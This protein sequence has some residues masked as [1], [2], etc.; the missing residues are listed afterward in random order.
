MKPPI[1]LQ[2]LF[3]L[4]LTAA[5]PLTAGAQTT[6]FFSDDFTSG[7]ASTVNQPDA[8][9][10]THSTSYQ[11]YLNG[12]PSTNTVNP[13]SLTLAFP[14]STSIIGELAGRFTNSPVP[15][16]ADGDFLTL[17]VIF[18]NTANLLTNSSGNS[19]L[20]VGLYNS[21]GA[22]LNQGPTILNALTNIANT[23]GSQGWI[24]YVS[25]MFANGGNATCYTRNP[26]T[27]NGTSAQNQDLLF[28]NASSTAGYNLPT[29]TVLTGG[30]TVS[31]AAGVITS[32]PSSVYTLV[33][34]AAFDTPTGVLV[35]NTLYSGAGTGGTVVFTQTKT[36]TNT[37]FVT[38]GFDS[39]AIGWRNASSV[40]QVTTMDINS[41]TVVGHS[42][43]VTGPPH[44]DSQPV[45][46]NIPS[47]SAG[48]F[49]VSATGFG[50]GYQWHRNGTNLLN[51][52][53]IS[54]A[55][56]SI[57]VINPAGPADVAPSNNPNGYY[58]TV[59]GAGGYFTNS[60]TNAL[61][62]TTATNLI[63]SGNLTTWDL[64]NTADWLDPLSNLVPFNFGDPVTFDDTGAGGNVNLAG[65]FLSAASVTV[66][67][68]FNYNFASTSS[69]SFAGPGS[70][71][72]SGPGQLTIGNVNTYTGGTSITNS[73]TKILLQNLSG[74]GSGPINLA[75]PAAQI[76]IT[77]A[78]ATGVGIASDVN[79]ADN[80]AITF[81]AVGT[82]S[83][84]FNGDWSGTVGKTLTLNPSPT[85]TVLNQRVRLLG[86]NTVY[87]GNLVLNASCVTVANY[88][89]SGNHIF[90]G[91]VSG[92]GQMMQRGNGLTIF[93]GAN[94]Y[95]GG[96][97]PTT[98]AIGFGI[99]SVGAVTT[100]PIGTGPLILAPEIP[101]LTG[102][103]AVLAYG[104][105]RT[106]A[107]PIQYP[108]ATNNLTLIT[109]GT[110]NLTFSGPYTL[111]GLDGLGT[112]NI[113]TFQ[114]DNAGLTTISGVISDGGLAYGLTK[115]GTNTLALSNTETYTGPTTVSA[116]IL[117]VNGALNAASTV[118][119]TTNATLAGTGTINGA[120]TITNGTLAPGAASI[121][122][123]NLANNLTFTGTGGMK[124]RVNRS[125]SQADK[126]I[127]G[128]TLSN[129]GTGIVT[130]TN[131]G[132]TL[133]VGDTF[134]LFSTSVA[135][136]GALTVTGGGVAWN[137][138]LA[139]GGTISVAAIL[140]FKPVITN[141]VVV[142]GTNLIF[143]G[144]N[145]TGTSGGSYYVRSATNVNTPLVS[146]T[147]VSTNTFGTSGAFSVTNT[148]VP[149]EP[150][151]FYLLS[152][153]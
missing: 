143:R 70:L 140:S 108:S 141:T 147:F 19:T 68:A 10:T 119:V 129:V 50:V 98:G 122:T 137:N 45:S 86:T 138:N 120:V 41:I 101:N 48:A 121:G 1:N 7:S 21:G 40:S 126:A 99:D 135:G 76:E 24:G 72:Y 87:N 51:G 127:V 54:G 106:I 65:P 16:V 27:A 97:T 31:P 124:V 53:N 89:G 61:T 23:G 133:Q 38:S 67:S 46:A 118:T 92:P 139:S 91:V 84:V 149:G 12:A 8:T 85:N 6:T 128:G 109:S 57:L 28:N 102:S 112:N 4:V 47:G 132:A 32:G 96:T 15:L 37:S 81:D 30:N 11:V 44:I 34:S 60:V 74:L 80:F 29:G 3:A 105:A 88:Q 36:A 17:T 90:N 117:Q 136:G 152:L 25:R 62:L 82:F 35:T 150:R 95:S 56:S 9:P 145:A 110:N 131:L 115:T 55:N 75:A 153:P 116:G 151:R 130:V 103:G 79:V 14:T 42:T 83:G 144:T 2:I 64:N 78:G 49:F 39:F 125:G 13:T 5:L 52:G 22:A 148:V 33:L 104:G 107:N 146:W 43:V 100:G 59:S 18:T 134:T 123:L 142:G 26:Q 20:N 93:N 71:T 58:V 77:V 69:G 66:N 63:W 111:N 114:A 113:R 94:T 73:A